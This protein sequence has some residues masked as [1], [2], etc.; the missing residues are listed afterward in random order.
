MLHQ[1]HK[2]NADNATHS[3]YNNLRVTFYQTYTTMYAY[4]RK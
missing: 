3:K 2:Q 4:D 1:F